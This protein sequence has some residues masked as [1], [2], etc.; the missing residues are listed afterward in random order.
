M[1]KW[2]L[3]HMVLYLNG[4]IMVSLI[5]GTEIVIHMEK[6]KLGFLSHTTHK[7]KFYMD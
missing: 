6:V 4:E 2:N 1:N 5:N 3:I 7:N